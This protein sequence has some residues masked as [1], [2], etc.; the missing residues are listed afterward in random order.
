MKY[1]ISDLVSGPM[2]EQFTDKKV[3][4]Q[5]LKEVIAEGKRMNLESSNGES[6]LGSNGMRVE[7]FISLVN[8]PEITR[9][10]YYADTSTMDGITEAQ[11]VNYRQWAESEMKAAYPNADIEV[12]DFGYVGDSII[13]GD[14]GCDTNGALNFCRE[15][16]SRCPWPEAWNQVDGEE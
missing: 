12:V 9:I 3:A 7:D 6:E 14:A 16:F 5:E 1:Q 8:I 10:K 11:A 15:L 2:G 13:I 4:E